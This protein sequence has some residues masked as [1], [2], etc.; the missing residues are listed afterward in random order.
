[1]DDFDFARLTYL[2]VLGS[3]VV[4][5]FFAVNRGSMN[6]VLQQAMIWGFL[7]IG[8][9]AAHGLWD[10]VRRSSVPQQMVS[11]EGGQIELP[12]SSDGHYYLTADVNGAF[13]DFVVD[14]GAT[15]IVLSEADARRAGFTPSELDYIGRAQT[16]NG[17]VRIAPVRIDRFA[18]GGIEDVGVRAVVNEGDLDGSLLGMSY[19]QRF[20]S[21]EISGGRLV[22][23]R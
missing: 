18:V 20:N 3:A 17:E 14:T 13:I 1:M 11:I 9:I 6:K 22:L 5:W 2:V 21:V 23:T 8:V 16:A 4:F 12:L 15:D 19:L 10:D 7:F